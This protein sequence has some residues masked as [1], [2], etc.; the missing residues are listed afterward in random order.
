MS[1]G[2]TLTIIAASD[3]QPSGTR[4]SRSDKVER[5]S[6]QVSVDLLQRKFAE[7]MESIEAAFGIDEVKTQAGLFELEEIQFSAELSASGDFKLLGTGVG[8]SA[9]SAL[10]F[11]LRRK[12]Q[13]PTTS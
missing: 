5:V 10:A 7:F 6:G 12:P 2:T 9:G 8:V 4:S 1:N 3:Q 13:T 11:V